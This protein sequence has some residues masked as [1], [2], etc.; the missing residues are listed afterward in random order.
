MRVA[1]VEREV[2]GVDGRRVAL[3]LDA[4]AH[5]RERE[6]GVGGARDGDGLDAV[7][8]ALVAG[9]FEGVVEAHIGVER[10]VFRARLF[11]R[12]RVVER[13]RDLRLFGEEF[14][15]FNRSG[16][17][18]GLVIVF[19]AH[20]NAF[21]QATEALGGVAALHIDGAEVG[22]LHIQ[23][24]L[25]GPAALVAVFLQ[26]QLVHPDFARLLRSAEV[27]HADNHRFHLAER[28]VAHNANFILRTVGVVLRVEA[29][30]G[31]Q[32]L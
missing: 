8:L 11:L 21:F 20:R 22:E 1:V 31:G 14:A 27:S 29:V 13:R 32:A 16:D 10:V 19:R 25:R 9:G 17:A 12:H 23:V 18:V 4:H 2:G 6:I 3:V 24:A 15:E 30:V 28:R 26:A 7:A 5:V